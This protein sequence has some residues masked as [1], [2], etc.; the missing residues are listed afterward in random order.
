M[1]VVARWLGM[2]LPWPDAPY[3]NPA[4][5]DRTPRPGDV[6][7]ALVRLARTHWNKGLFMAILLSRP[8]PRWPSVRASTLRH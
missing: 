7:L 5:P 8:G 6:R 2:R 1:R 4:S 3:R